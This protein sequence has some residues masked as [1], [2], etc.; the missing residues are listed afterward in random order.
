[1]CDR[2]P[3]VGFYSDVPVF[4]HISF[5]ILREN[6]FMHPIFLQA[7]LGERVAGLLKVGTKVNCIRVHS[8]HQCSYQVTVALKTKAAHPKARKAVVN[9]STA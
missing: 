5:L 7:D 1:M 6:V 4:L 8:A 2:A 3:T 9:Q